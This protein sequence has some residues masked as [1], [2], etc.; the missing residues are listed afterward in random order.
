MKKAIVLT[1]FILI[2]SLSA[3]P[4]NFGIMKGNIKMYFPSIKIK[5]ATTYVR[6]VTSGIKGKKVDLVSN[7]ISNTIQN[8]S[9][10]AE[11]LCG[12]DKAFALDNFNTD[13]STF[14]KYDNVLI[15]VSA[16]AIC[17]DYTKL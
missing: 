13:I 2:S 11:K 4:L 8:F 9:K 7:S 14:G 15:V 10:Q 12:Q 6:T 1:L 16:N 17:F 3:E 5:N